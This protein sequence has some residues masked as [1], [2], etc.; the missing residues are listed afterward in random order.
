M[1]TFIVCRRE[2]LRVRPADV[3]Q[4]RRALATDPAIAAPGPDDDEICQALY[5][6]RALPAV[7]DV[8]ADPRA[9]AGGRAVRPTACQPPPPGPAPL[10]AVAIH[11]VGTEL[12]LVRFAPRDDD[13]PVTAAIAPAAGAMCRFVLQARPEGDTTVVLKRFSVGTTQ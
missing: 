3:A 13:A 9:H 1:S 6:A 8:M 2:T 11:E 5:F 10:L 7:L 4:C 12:I